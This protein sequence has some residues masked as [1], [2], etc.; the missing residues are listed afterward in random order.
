MT[1]VPPTTLDAVIDGNH[2]PPPPVE[3]WAPDWIYDGSLSPYDPRR[4]VLII[5]HNEIVPFSVSEDGRAVT[6]GDAVSPSRPILYSAAV[7]WTSP[8][9]VLVAAGTVFGEIVVWQCHLDAES[10]SRSEVLFV[11]TGHEGS[12]FGVAISPE[13][14]LG[15]GSKTRLL[16]SC[17]DDRTIRIWDITENGGPSKIFDETYMKSSGEAR[18][19][20]FCPGSELDTIDNAGASRCLA[21]A[22]G[23]ASRIWHVKFA[24]SPAHTGTLISPATVYSF[25]ED[26][27]AHKWE[28]CL[29]ADDSGGPNEDAID[30]TGRKIP[31][32]LNKVERFLCHGGKHI[33]SAAIAT[34]A[35]S[36]AVIATGGADG[37]ITL[38]GFVHKD[39]ATDSTNNDNLGRRTSNPAGNNMT[40]SYQEVLESLPV[41]G[42]QI[43]NADRQRKDRVK[44]GFVRYA[45]LSE[46][47]VLVST[48]SG[49]V[50]IGN[51][52]RELLW[53]EVDTS[54][55]IREDLKSYSVLDSPGCGVAFLGS[56]SGRLYLCREEHGIQEVATFDGKIAGL[57]CL[58]ESNA[59]V[60][61]TQVIGSTIG[62]ESVCTVLVAILGHPQATLLTVDI[63]GETPSVGRVPV[64]VEKGTASSVGICGEF[65]VVGTRSGAV[66]VYAKTPD[67]FAR[68]ISRLDCK[69]KDAVTAILTLPPLDGEVETSFLTTCRD[70]KYRVYEIQC[71]GDEVFLHLRHET[72]PPL[73]PMLEGAWFAQTQDDGLDLIIFGFRSTSFVVWNETKQQEIAA[74]AC[75][76]GHRTFD[77]VAGHGNPER[78]RFVYSKSSQMGIYSQSR[79]SLRALRQGNHGRE[80]RSVAA[81]GKYLATGA[82]D[83]CIRIWEYVRDGTSWGDMRC[84]A[85]LGKHVTGIQCLRW[86]GEEYLLSSS[87]NEEFFVWRV[88]R[89]R[90]QYKGLSVVCEATYPDR[91]PVG[92][93]RIMD[94]DVSAPPEGGAGMIV[95]LVFSNS[96]LKTYR[97][98]QGN[99]FELLAEGRYTGCCLTQI[100]HLHLPGGA[101]GVV[102]ASTDGHLAVWRS[103]DEGEGEGEGEK[104]T[105]RDGTD[106]VSHYALAFATKVHQSSVKCL[107]IR[108]D[109]MESGIGWQVVT[110]GDD[111]ALGILNIAWLEQHHSFE[112]TGR[113]RVK[114]AHAAAV[115]G[116]VIVE[117]S[118]TSTLVATVSNDQRIKVWRVGRARGGVGGVALVDNQYSAI[119]DP[120][121]LEQFAQGTLMV[122]GVGI[123]AWR[124]SPRPMT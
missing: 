37:K 111:N 38:I 23:H 101:I 29:D 42:G 97:Y 124:W 46:D 64:A 94:F 28:L 58:P 63:S 50:L 10:P 89:P 54:D 30:G 9:C 4:G 83:T 90:S 122:A 123:E 39:G 51:M 80:I 72:S 18:E 43:A 36:P 31:G 82:E 33:W 3:A 81:S 20:G 95:S 25:G 22:M 102:T 74:V 19:T 114:D 92:D 62:K 7:S 5:A 98:S 88:T 49:R 16:A 68:R 65:M 73:G 108:H 118:D 100:R 27:T 6:F 55:A 41:T 76:G 87:G 107:D 85:V 47:R 93:L 99:G 13:L 113:A 15:T 71:R 35:E 11:F 69:T 34:P 66:A 24:S 110:G 60:D 56:R 17:S 119:A 104:S 121:D 40:L 116:A 26:S 86:Y 44:E 59:R 21:V 117:R 115:T 52:A 112:V 1:T 48:S 91:T 109:P 2:V 70:G 12:I 79:V 106:G 78:L 75:G 45:F 8:A 61:A 14:E 67:G 53:T 84:L 77:Y 105:L 120:G 96:S 32:S 103:E 57:F